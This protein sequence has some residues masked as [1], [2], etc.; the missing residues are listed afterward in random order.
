MLGFGDELAT[1]TKVVEKAT[2]EATTSGAPPYF[3]N[4]VKKIKNMGDETTATKDKTTAYQYDDYYMEEDFAGNIE[5]TRKGDMD[6]MNSGYEEV[7][8]S[9]RVDEVP[10]K[11]KQ[12]SRK[13][14]EYEEYTARP[15]QDGKMKDVEDGVPDDVIE[16]GTMFE[17]NIAEFGK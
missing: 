12:G 16:E 5:I 2:K 3:L 8:M 4:L 15:D 1:T 6:D 7:Y 9:Y 11:G 17:D 10:I 14:E 13:V